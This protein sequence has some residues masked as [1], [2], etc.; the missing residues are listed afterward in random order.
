MFSRSAQ[1]ALM[2][3]AASTCALPALA[4]EGLVHNLVVAADPQPFTADDLL[5]ME[6]QA[7]GVQL[8]DTLNVYASRS[9][10][11]VPIGELSRV[12][13]L[14]IGVFPGQ[15]RAEGWVLSPENKLV[16]DLVAGV[17]RLNGR[18]LQIGQGQAAIYDND[19]YVRSDL[20][21]QLLPL[22][23]KADT[24]AQVLTLTP[25]AELPFQQRAERAQRQA[26]L[27]EGATSDDEA[28]R[29]DNPYGLFSPPA[30]DVNV[31]GQLARDGVDQAGSYDV[32]VAHDLLHAGFEGFVGSNDDGEISTVRVMLSRKDPYG[33][34]LGPLR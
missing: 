32:R 4:Q 13:D 1:G 22:K 5:W 21:E 23:L 2:A 12:L 28:V 29:I 27:G 7:D 24:S 16:V 11:F 34:A 9:G 25:T 30:F 26:Q 8:T 6:V 14:A 17:A 31:G 33:R 19:L 3:L 18:T 10:V 20:L 15:R